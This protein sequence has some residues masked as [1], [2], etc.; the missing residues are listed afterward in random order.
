MAVVNLISLYPASQT[1]FSHHGHIL[2]DVTN[3]TVTWKLNNQFEL[4]FDYPLDSPFA[5]DLQKEMIVTVPV[6]NLSGHEQAFRI[7]KVTKSM[8]TVTIHAYHVFW[9][10]MQNFIEDTNVVEKN[11]ADAIAQ[12]LGGT[13]FKHHFSFN[14]NVSKIATARLVRKSV[15]TALIGTENNG[16]LNRW[17]GEFD[18]D[19]FHFDVKEKIGEDRGVV[20]RNKKNLI[21]YSAEE[22]FS[23]VVTRI[24][25]EGSDGLFLPEKYVDSPLIDNYSTP[26]I[27]KLEFSNVKAINQNKTDDDSSDDGIPLNQ[28]YDLLRKAASKEFSDN[29]LDKPTTTYNLNVVLLENSEEYK[30]TNIFTK[31]YPGDTA[32]F[33]HDEDKLNIKAEL[34][35]YTWSPVQQEYLTVTFQSASK[36]TTDIN[37]MIDDEMAARKQ[38]VEQ[39]K[40]DI[41][42][43]TTEREKSDKDLDYKI[44]DVSNDLTDKDKEWQEKAKEFQQKIDDARKDMSDF[45]NSGGTH[46]IEWVPNLAKATQMK[47][48]TDNGY[49]L[50]DDHGVGFHANDGTVMTGMDARGNFIANNIF[51]N[52]LNGTTINGGTMNSVIMNAGQINATDINGGKI[53]GATNIDMQGVHISWY[54]ISTPALT[55]DGQIDGVHALGMT[56]DAW[57][58]IGDYKITASDKRLYYGGHPLKFADE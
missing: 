43:E 7:D 40:D 31:V 32:T 1:D 12:I 3:D 25:P 13:Q 6:P 2:Q 50:I 33:I 34:T 47:I 27:A 15:I 29:N 11:G 30:D 39:M 28:A 8:G 49:L 5:F 35:G 14:S 46:I 17:G 56:R 37:Q 23:T 22:D 54:G 18:W 57:I 45:M 55:V 42:K 21:G 58:W 4:Q 48:H 38:S 26:R 52:V 53:T 19:N 41:E 20:F 36:P 44:S 51:G 10:L 9:D 24:M 16:F